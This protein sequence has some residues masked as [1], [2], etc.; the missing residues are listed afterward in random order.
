MALVLLTAASAGSTAYL[1]GL[2]SYAT[3]GIG[4]GTMALSVLLV[5]TAALATLLHLKPLRRDG[6]LL[7]VGGGLLAA[8]PSAASAVRSSDVKTERKDGRTA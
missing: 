5:Q 7:P 2:R 3:R 4:L 1:S 6:W 8:P